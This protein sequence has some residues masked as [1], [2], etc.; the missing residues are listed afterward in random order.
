MS[1][2]FAAI[3]LFFIL[4]FINIYGDA[5]HWSSQKNMLFSFYY[6]GN[7]FRL[8]LARYDIIE[9]GQSCY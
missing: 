6:W 7:H 2:G 9:Q 1:V 3:S 4:R 5:V 8:Q